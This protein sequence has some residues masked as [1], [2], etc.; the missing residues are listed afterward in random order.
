MDFEL[1]EKH[2]LGLN[3][4]LRAQLAH[5]LLESIDKL[6]PAEIETLWLDEAGRRAREIDDGSVTLIPADEVAQKARALLR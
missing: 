2:A 1:I 6:P 5:E 4:H 3:V